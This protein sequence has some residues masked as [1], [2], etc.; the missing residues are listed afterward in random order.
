[1]SK[2]LKI[3]KKLSTPEFERYWQ[4]LKA[5]MIEVL[6]EDKKSKKEKRPMKRVLYV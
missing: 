3:I 4:L 6:R 2:K 1:M 5:G